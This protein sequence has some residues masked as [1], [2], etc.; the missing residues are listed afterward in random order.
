MQT[1]ENRMKKK[2]RSPAVTVI[3]LIILVA[4]AGL[5]TNIIR[6]RMPTKERMDLLEF[7]GEAPEGEAILILH[8]DIMEKHA[9]LFGET[10]YLSLGIVNTYLNQRYYW[11]AENRQIIYATPSEVTYA[12]ASDEGGGDVWL[13]NED[14]YLSIPYVQRYTDID[15]YYNHSPERVA[16]QYGFE[17]L[18]AVTAKKNTAVRYQGGIKSPILCDVSAGS[19]L[20]LAA[21][22]ENWAQ[23]FTPDGYIGYVQKSVYEEASGEQTARDSSI[24]QYSHTSFESPVNLVWH[25]VTVADANSYFESDTAA[26]SGVNVISPTWYTMTDNAG[27]IKDISSADYVSAAHNKGM[28]VWALIDNFTS[29]MSTF[30]VLSHTA[31]RQ[32]LIGNLV[33]SVVG[34]GADGINIDFE[35]LS[36]ETGVHFLQFLREL[37]VECHRNNLILSVDNPVPEDFTSHYDRA[38]QGRVVDYVIIMGY[39]E[40][41]VGSVEAG[42]VAS[43]PWVEQG[44]ADTIAEVPPEKVILGIPFYCRLWKVMAESLSS[45][46]LGMGEANR[47]VSEHKVELYWDNVACQHVGSYDADGANWKI[48]LEDA[49]SIAAKT[50]LVNKYN[51]AGTAAWKLGLEES[52]VWT[53]ISEHL[54]R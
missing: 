10:A 49:E 1:K 46:A 42:S 53:V 16:I 25:Q 19:I 50:D 29:D 34:C 33:S 27:N 14:V 2:K 23:V 9:V 26:V 35:T 44:I 41:Y 37:S 4:A 38:E 20:Y 36:E 15:V 54:Q 7:Y 18:K 22:L 51:L 47:V 11:D 8:S 43:L 52:P 31:S 3:V 13:H 28:Q 30:E 12:P 21:E 5:L 32:A 40:H 24:E 39:D 45:E 17:N 6:S 48:W